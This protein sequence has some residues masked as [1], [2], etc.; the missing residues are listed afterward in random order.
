MIILVYIYLFLIP[1]ATGVYTVAQNLSIRT[2][3]A[4]NKSLPNSDRWSVVFGGVQRQLSS[5]DGLLK[6]SKDMFVSVLDCEKELI[7]IMVHGKLDFF[8]GSK[9][10]NFP[11]SWVCMDGRLCM[12]RIK[13]GRAMRPLMSLPWFEDLSFFLSSMLIN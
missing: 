4:F 11:T 6:Y 12:Q 5:C 9:H 2:F 13:Q 7:Y 1:T 8:R 10:L 3:V